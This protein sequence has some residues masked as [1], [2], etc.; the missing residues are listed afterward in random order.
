MEGTTLALRQAG[1][2][3]SDGSLADYTAHPVLTFP[4]CYED[5][6]ILRISL[7]P[8]FSA[9]VSC[10]EGWLVPQV[11]S[12]CAKEAVAKLLQATPPYTAGHD[13][14]WLSTQ[15]R[16]GLCG[17][18]SEIDRFVTA[19]PTAGAADANGKV[20]TDSLLSQIVQPGST[21]DPPS[22][23]GQWL[24]QLDVFGRRCN[25]GPTT[26]AIANIARATRARYPEA[27]LSDATKREDC[28]I[29]LAVDR[30]DAWPLGD[31]LLAQVTAARLSDAELTRRSWIAT[32][33]TLQTSCT[34]RMSEQQ[35]TNVQALRK[36]L[37]RL[38][39]G[40]TVQELLEA[41][42]YFT[43]GGFSEK[44]LAL[45]VATPLLPRAISTGA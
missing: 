42:E 41:V 35:R 3:V 24:V 4:K 6:Q 10:R 43:R 29:L 9:V 38:V 2:L 25:K 36:N 26:E 22:T 28:P 39:E 8:G 30:L 13:M 31:K 40:K 19:F 12:S 14:A 32:L 20:D 44:L 7:E 15:N 23:W 1:F 34:R 18:P 21:P 16:L 37:D 45:L 17:D 5:E 27:D 11:A 33:D